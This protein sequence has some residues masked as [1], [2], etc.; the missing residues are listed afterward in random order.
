MRQAYILDRRGMW[1]RLKSLNLEPVLQEILNAP[2]GSDKTAVLEVPTKPL[3]AKD[4]HVISGT[5]YLTK[6]GIDEAAVTGLCFVE[7]GK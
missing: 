3:H 7:W 4:G 2:P 5:R 6:Q 1:R